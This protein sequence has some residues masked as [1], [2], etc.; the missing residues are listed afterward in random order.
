MNDAGPVAQVVETGNQGKARRV[1]ILCKAP[2]RFESTGPR[3][4]SN[5]A[6]SSEVSCG[7]TGDVLCELESLMKA[8]WLLANRNHCTEVYQHSLAMPGVYMVESG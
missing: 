8:S 3:G 5:P 1:P 4:V 6:F 7:A 2:K